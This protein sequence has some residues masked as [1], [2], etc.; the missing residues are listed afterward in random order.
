MQAN[1]RNIIPAVKVFCTLIKIFSKIMIEGQ[2]LWKELIHLLSVQGQLIKAVLS[3][4]CKGV[5]F[6]RLALDTIFSFF[7]ETACGPPVKPPG[8][9]RRRRTT[10]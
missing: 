5:F 7:F 6:I 9:T 1:R 2:K 3:Q 4:T 10:V 8:T